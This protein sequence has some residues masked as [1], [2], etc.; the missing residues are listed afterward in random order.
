MDKI[1]DNKGRFIKGLKKELHPRWKGGISQIKSRYGKGKHPNSRNGFKKGHK[2]FGNYFKPNEEHPEW[3]GNKAGLSSL[4]YWVKRRK[5][6]PKKCND[7]NKKEKLCLANIS[8]EYK[9]DINDFEWLCYPCHYQ[10]DWKKI[11]LTG[12]KATWEFKK[13][14]KLLN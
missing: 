6:K 7:C 5:P 1:R 14:L 4:H 12:K 3:K 2:P 8:G 11:K 13:K 10:K 9:R